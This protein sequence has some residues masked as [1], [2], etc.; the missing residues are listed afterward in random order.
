[1]AFS[2]GSA[3]VSLTLTPAEYWTY[4]PRIDPGNPTYD[5][6]TGVIANNP[7]T[8]APWTIQEI[9]SRHGP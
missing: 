5:A 4:A 8:G 3:S 9:I 7:A 6:T 2:T 1:V